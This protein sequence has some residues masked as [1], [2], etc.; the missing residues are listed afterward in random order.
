MLTLLDTMTIVGYAFDIV[1]VIIV[2]IYCVKAVQK[3]FIKSLMSTVGNIAV[4]VG[5]VYSAKYVAG[6]LNKIYNFTALISGK[7]TEYFA[8]QGEFYT[9]TRAAG[10]EGSSL[11]GS[12]P[13][14]TFGLLKRIIRI[15]LERNPFTEEASVADVLGATLGSLIFIVVAGILTYIVFKIVLA[16]LSK[17]LSNATKGTT[18]GTLDKFLGLLFGLARSALTIGVGMVALVGLTFIP[19]VNNFIDPTIHEHTQVT[20]YVYDFSNDL[21]ERYVINNVDDWITSLWENRTA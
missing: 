4:I 10:T 19:A 11:V 5:S 17:T 2:L 18:F 6:L 20:K 1:L 8:T 3:G 13:D 14:S 15:V 7:I 21:L 9:V 16:F 12:I